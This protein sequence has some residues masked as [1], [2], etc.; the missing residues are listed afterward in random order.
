MTAISTIISKKNLPEQLDFE[1]GFLLLVDKPLE[2]TS[3]DAVNKIRFS[4]KHKLQKKKYKVGHAGT[5]DPLATGLLL[6]CCGKYTKLIE[7]LQNQEKAYDFRMKLGFRTETYDA[8][9][10]EI[11]VS[12]PKDIVESDVVNAMAHFKG[13]ILQ[14]PPIYSAVKIKGQALYKL[15]RRGHNVEIKAR[16]VHVSKLEV[17]NFANPFVDVIMEC[18]K[19]T[20]VRSIAHDLGT[21]LKC[22]AY[23]KTLRRTEVG[24]YSV[25]DALSIQECVEFINKVEV[26]SVN[27]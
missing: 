26:L 15:A 16:P 24:H 23:V 13:D 6:I 14:K 10:D 22:G 21:F 12:D 8:E 18:S 25:N 2:W 3:F 1:S 19:G 9:S 7:S 17:L 27:D 5:L 20:Y 11:F 4:C